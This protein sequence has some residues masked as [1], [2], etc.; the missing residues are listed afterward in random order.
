MPFTEKVIETLE[1]DFFDTLELE[2]GEFEERTLQVVSP[3]HLHRASQSPVVELTSYCPSPTILLAVSL[4]GECDELY[5]E[6]LNVEFDEDGRGS[7]QFP[8][9]IFNKMEK[10][11]GYWFAVWQLPGESMPPV[12]NEFLQCL[13]SHESLPRVNGSTLEYEDKGQTALYELGAN[14][15]I[16]FQRD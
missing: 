6:H 7:F 10:N 16:G 2:E 12:R 9:R 11:L 14:R 15:E 4:G 1:P 5:T 13:I 3:R 8:E